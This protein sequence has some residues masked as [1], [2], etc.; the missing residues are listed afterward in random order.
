MSSSGNTL[1]HAKDLVA[2]WQKAGEKVVFTNGVFDILHVGHVTYLTAAKALGSRLVVG[3]NAD[4]SVRRLNKAPDR[5]INPQQ[6]RLTVLEALRC[7]DLA[8]VFEEDTPLELINTL[9]PDILVKGG[10]YDPDSTDPADKRYM[11]GS[12]EVRSW[13]GIVQT[14]PLVE[15]Y[16]TT[17]ILKKRG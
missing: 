14:I 3:V 12:K 9:R 4:E 2:Q 11:V 5:P 16:S 17:A 13:G 6:A 10:D 15:G 1:E 7:V 8:I